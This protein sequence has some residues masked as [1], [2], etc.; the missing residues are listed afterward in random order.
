MTAA[1]P[2]GWVTCELLEGRLPGHAASFE[3]RGPGFRIA[4]SCRTTQARVRHIQVKII[5]AKHRPGG[6]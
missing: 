4:Q 6:S 2:R 3:N 5:S 1:N